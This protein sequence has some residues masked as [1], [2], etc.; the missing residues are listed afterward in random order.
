MLTRALIWWATLPYL[1][2]VAL[3]L[4]AAIAVALTLT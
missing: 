1:A 3:K 2:R 4:T